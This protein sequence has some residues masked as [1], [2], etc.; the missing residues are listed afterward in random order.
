MQKCPHSRNYIKCCSQHTY[1]ARRELSSMGWRIIFIKYMKSI[2]YTYCIII[3]RVCYSSIIRQFLHGNMYR[4]YF[5]RA[6][7]YLGRLFTPKS[8]RASPLISLL[9]PQ[10]SS[11]GFITGRSKYNTIIYSTILHT[12]LRYSLY[13]L[14]SASTRA[15]ASFRHA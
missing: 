7:A 2:H 13:H 12:L 6:P 3:S 1:F 11:P 14:I 10:S 8:L 9:L 5:T 4:L 15:S